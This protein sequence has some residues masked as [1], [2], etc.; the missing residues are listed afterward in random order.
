[1]VQKGG[2]VAEVVKEREDVE[3]EREARERE[4]ERE[5]VSDRDRERER[6]RV[7]QRE[8]RMHR[9]LFPDSWRER[10]GGEEEGRRKRRKALRK[11][12]HAMV[13]KRHKQLASDPVERDALSS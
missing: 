6:E 8:L 9:T 10:T 11:E 7:S 4:G 5:T 3:E 1:V 12:L 2:N 13:K